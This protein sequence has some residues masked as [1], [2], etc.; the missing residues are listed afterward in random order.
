MCIKSLLTGA[1]YN[2]LLSLIGID[3]AMIKK[4]EDFLNA[5]N[6]FIHQLNCCYNEHYKQLERFE[7]L[8]GHKSI[9]LEIP[10]QIRAYQNRKSGRKEHG[11]EPS[12]EHVT[13]QLMEQLQ[14]KLIKNL[15][16]YTK[17]QGKKTN[18]DIPDCLIT[19]ANINDLK[20]E[21]DV[22]KCKFSCPFC[23]KTF[24]V[25]YKKFWMSSNATKHLKEHLLSDSIDNQM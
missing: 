23:S 22:I 13:K 21:L 17:E 18:I 15:L 25:T 2:T 10:N 4:T 5:N 6:H 9:I 12:T 14:A 3:E 8:P 24:S 1:G 11:K 20:R 7:F 19:E 16:N